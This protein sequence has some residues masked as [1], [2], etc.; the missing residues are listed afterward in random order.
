MPVSCEVVMTS[1]SESDDDRDEY[2]YALITPCLS[3]LLLKHLSRV[4]INA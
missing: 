3:K 1:I 2:Q 4:D